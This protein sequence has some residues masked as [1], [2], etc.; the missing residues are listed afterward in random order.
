[1]IARY[2]FLAILISSLTLILNSCF[3]A[4]LHKISKTEYAMGTEVSITLFAGDK[5]KG[6]RLLAEAFGLADTLEKRVSAT[7]DTSII[8]LINKRNRKTVSDPFVLDLLEMSR[9]LTIETDGYF[10]P[11]LGRLIALWDFENNPTLP[12]NTAIKQELLHSGIRLFSMQGSTVTLVGGAQLDLG[13]IAKGAIVDEMA[14]HLLRNGISN[15]LI[16]GGGDIAVRGRYNNKRDWNIAIADPFNNNGI[17]GMISLDTASIVTS[18][19]YERYFTGEDGKRYHH[20]LDPRTGYPADSGIHSVTVISTDTAYADAMATAI[21]VM[22]L[23]KGMA[24]VESYDNIEAIIVS[25]GQKDALI[26]VSNG[27]SS[28]KNSDGSWTFSLNRTFSQ[29][30]FNE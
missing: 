9:S 18:G 13:A 11:T 14:S 5:Q 21:F 30:L 27:I 22:G 20:I 12:R 29:S 24:F 19:D 4:D 17:M 10:D 23:E 8:S 25:S 28:K 16:N 3:S 7:I 15:F 2:R 1:M 6:E 26:E